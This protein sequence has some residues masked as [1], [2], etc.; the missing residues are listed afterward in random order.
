MNEPKERQDKQDRLPKI[1]PLVGEEWSGTELEGKECVVRYATQE[2]FDG[3]VA[4]DDDRAKLRHEKWN[5]PE[6]TLEE[7]QAHI[8]QGLNRS[9]EKPD[10]LSFVVAAIDG[11]VAGYIEVEKSTDSEY[12]IGTLSVLQKYMGKH[13]GSTLYKAFEEEMLAAHPEL[14]KIT[15]GTHDLNDQTIKLGEDGKVI[16]GFWHNMGYRE[17]GEREKHDYRWEI[18]GEPRDVSRIIMA[19]HFDR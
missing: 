8:R 19:K 12:R 10:E 1:I 14:N 15:L 13:I 2:D 17:E 11:E 4:V 7:I 3:L 16:G 5:T 6:K 18:D 9:F